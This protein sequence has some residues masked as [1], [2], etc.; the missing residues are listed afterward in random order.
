MKIQIPPNRTRTCLVAGLFAAM[1]AATASAATTPLQAQ[2]TSRPVTPGDKTV[3]SLPAALEVSGGLKTVAIGAP[4]YLD[5]LVNIAIPPADITGVTWALSKPYGSMAAMGPSPLGA[6]IP[7]YEPSE[8]LVSQVAGRQLFRPDLEGQYTVTATITTASEGTTNVTLTLTASTYMGIN[9]CKLCHSGGEV[10]PDRVHPWEKT[11]HSMIFSNGI[12]GYRGHYS[13]SCL[14][15]HTVGYDTNTNAVN[16]GFDDLM[17]QTGWLFPTVLS[18]TNWN[19]LPAALQNLGNIQCE[20]CHGPGSQHAH[21]LGDTNL[22]T[23]TIA[24]GDCNQ[25]HDA[26]THHIKGTEWYNSMHAVTTRDPA[27][28]A[29]CVGCHTSD[30]FIARI[31]GGPTNTAYSA[32]GCQTCHEPHGI[33]M[34]T[35]NPHLLRTL[36]AVTLM[37]GTVITNAGEGT[38]CMDCHHSRQNAAT[39]AATSPGSSHFGPHHGT[40]GDMLEGANGFTYGKIIPSSAHRDAVE[41]ACVTCH[42]QTVN[43]GEPAFLHAGGHTFWPAWETATNSIDLTAACQNCHGATAITTSFNFPLQDYNGDGVIEGVQTE[44]QHLLDKLSTYLPPVGPVKSSLSIDA[45]W[46]RPQLEGAYNWLFVHDDGSFGIHNTAYA[47]GLL[48]A[49]IA[50]LSGTSSPGGLPDW[51]VAQYFGSATNLNAAPNADPAGDGVPNWVKYA[52]GL[53]PLIPGTMLPNG[54]VV[55]ADGNSLGGNTPTNTIAIYTAA[56]VAFDTEVGKTYQIQGIS[57]LSG[58]WQNIAAPIQGTG[59]AYSYVTPTRQSVQQF[60]R[61]V[62]TP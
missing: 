42:M 20:N 23:R 8:R 40:Q 32:I 12:C 29:T 36:A 13:Q 53:N 39:Y 34:P 49:S 22:I 48:K 38:L 16:G 52:L 25:C 50:D 44:V 26:P 10:A 7:V 19:A 14:Q 47:V 43:P 59:A 17:A 55:W 54:S 56:E 35:N 18:P 3:Y 57:S 1:A 37:D 62:H 24:S 27:G 41:N 2:L 28:N 30:G 58:G 61:V 45:T 60:F 46:T 9:T 5:A 11:A 15:C 21:S 51:W 6:N 33:T 31:S 4:V